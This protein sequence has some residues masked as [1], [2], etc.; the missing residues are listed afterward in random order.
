[1]AFSLLTFEVS[2]E[3]L[4][5]GQAIHVVGDHPALGCWDTAKGV[6]LLPSDAIWSSLVPVSVPSGMPVQY[7]YIVVANGQLVRWEG[8]VGN[9]LIIPDG[10]EL[11][12]RD[13][14]DHPTVE[15]APVLSI[16]NLVGS[17]ATPVIGNAESSRAIVEA[18]HDNAVLVV[19]YILPLVIV[20]EQ[21]GGWS[22]DWNQV[23]AACWRTPPLLPPRAV[24]VVGSRRL[25]APIL[26]Q[27]R[28]PCLPHRTRSL[29]RNPRSASAN[30]SCGSAAPVSL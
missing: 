26:L 18:E 29:P 23:P 9:R 14:L 27:S 24:L 20:K 10:P 15:D 6:P 8:M 3:S 4:E 12:L 7:K 21:S 17:S 11:L 19:S 28:K 13:E 25:A 5:T 1:M 30:A 16:G 2:A 22:I